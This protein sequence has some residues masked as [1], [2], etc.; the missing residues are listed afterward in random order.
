MEERL[1]QLETEITDL[2]LACQTA[3]ANLALLIGILSATLQPRIKIEPSAIF[4]AI[5]S[6]GWSATLL[7]RFCAGQE[8][9]QQA[10]Q[11]DQGPQ[12]PLL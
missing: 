3:D 10:H 11:A 8:M 1:Q 2:R 5:Q 12:S 6:P 9:I 4:S 7:E